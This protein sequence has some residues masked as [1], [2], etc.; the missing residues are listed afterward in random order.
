MYFHYTCTGNSDYLVLFI[1]T[2]DAHKIRMLSHT[3]SLTLLKSV[4][5]GDG[6]IVKN[7]SGDEMVVVFTITEISYL[8]AS[9]FFDLVRA[10]VYLCL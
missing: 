5:G 3:L 2:G 1:K 8:V 10:I 7:D 4:T 6:N 9:L